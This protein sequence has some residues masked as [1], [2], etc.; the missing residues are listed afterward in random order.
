EGGEVRAIRGTLALNGTDRQYRSGWGERAAC[1]S[2][3]FSRR[4]PGLG[5]RRWGTGRHSVECRPGSERQ[6]AELRLMKGVRDW[7]GILLTQGTQRK[8]PCATLLSPFWLRERQRCGRPL[9]V[10]TRRAVFAC[11]IRLSSI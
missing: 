3:G 4:V 7:P 11:N 6:G 1:W 10:Q 8:R 5:S 2:K 9:S